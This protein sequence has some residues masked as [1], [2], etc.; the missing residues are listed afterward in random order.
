MPKQQKKPRTDLKGTVLVSVSLENGQG[1]QQKGNIR[2]NFR[3]NAQTVSTV[4]AALESCFVR[5]DVYS[6]KL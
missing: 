1:E 6:L 4:A 3:V 5:P 2:K